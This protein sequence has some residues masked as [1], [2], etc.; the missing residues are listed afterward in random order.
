M[1]HQAGRAVQNPWKILRRLG[2]SRQADANSGPE[3]GS[4]PGG[5][6]GAQSEE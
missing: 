6:G 1:F 3:A 4:A 5:M 2:F